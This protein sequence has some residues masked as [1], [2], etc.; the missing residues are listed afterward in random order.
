MKHFLFCIL[1]ILLCNFTDIV[2][3]QKSP[4]EKPTKENSGANY[5]AAQQL[6]NLITSPAFFNNPEKWDKASIACC[7]CHKFTSSGKLWAHGMSLWQ[8]RT[9]TRTFIYFQ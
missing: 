6:Y 5:F 9:I 1:S 7:K 3:T 4:I 2:A 8:R